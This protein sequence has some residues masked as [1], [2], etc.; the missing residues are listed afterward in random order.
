M[1]TMIKIQ[2]LEFTYGK[3][4]ILDNVNVDFPEAKLSI[5]MGKKW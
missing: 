4:K 2:N 5:V 1:E 3:Q